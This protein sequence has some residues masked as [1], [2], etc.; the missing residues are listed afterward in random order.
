M[1]KNQPQIANIKKRIANI[2]INSASIRN[3]GSSGIIE[4]TR[5]YLYEIDLNDFNKTTELAFINILDKHTENILARF[6]TPKNGKKSWGAARKA[7]NLFLEEA[8]YNRFLWKEYHM[9][10]FISFLEVP[11]DKIVAGKIN[12]GIE[13]EL[14]TFIS[15]KE[16]DSEKNRQYQKAASAIAKSKGVYRVY[17][18]L[19]YWDRT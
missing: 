18:D 8:S 11:V 6:P 17:L 10:N 2:I 1:D 7:I 5:S 9:E 3:Q 12:K 4:A 14:P 19:E 13:I 15:I 16:F